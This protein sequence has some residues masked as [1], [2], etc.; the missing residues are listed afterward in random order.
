MLL[1][2]WISNWTFNIFMTITYLYCSYRIEH[3]LKS[4]MKNVNLVCKRIICAI[5]IQ[6][7]AIKLVF[8]I[9][10][11]FIILIIILCFVFTFKVYRYFNKLE[12]MTRDINADAFHMKNSHIY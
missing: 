10:V 7:Q 12:I 9:L 4:R 11:I 8:K 2:K 5:D 3:S 6:G 1:C